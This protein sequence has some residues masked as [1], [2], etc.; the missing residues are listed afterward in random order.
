MMKWLNA[1]KLRKDLDFT[2]HFRHLAENGATIP[3][4]YNPNVTNYRDA[5][6][7]HV[8]QYKVA[9]DHALN[10][11]ATLVAQYLA[12][13]CD[14]DDDDPT[15][16]FEELIEE[17]RGFVPEKISP[18]V[19]AP[20]PVPDPAPVPDP[21]PALGLEHGGSSGATSA[22]LLGGAIIIF[23]IVTIPSG[24]GLIGVAIIA[25]AVGAN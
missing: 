8:D 3:N 15:Q 22:I 2:D 17:L 5:W 18:V 4:P 16:E 7:N 11:A 14:C 21:V 20:V 10:C 24:E 12:R 25:G 23:D 6:N 1:A 13:E 19:P 9:R